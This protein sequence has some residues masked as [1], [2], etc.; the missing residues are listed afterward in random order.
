MMV[1]HTHSP[2]SKNPLARVFA[3]CFWFMAFLIALFFLLPP[4][5]LAITPANKHLKHNRF[6]KKIGNFEGELYRYRFWNGG[7]I[8]AIIVG[9]SYVQCLPKSRMIA[10][11]GVTGAS[12][13]ECESL[14]KYRRNDELIF[15]VVSVREF[16]KY[17]P[18]R[19]TLIYQPYR[20]AFCAKLIIRDS[21]LGLPVKK[22]LNNASQRERD[23]L[24]MICGNATALDLTRTARQLINLDLDEISLVRYNKLHKK[25]SNIIFIIFPVAPLQWSPPNGERVREQANVF[26][27]AQTKLLSLFKA[28][29][30]P[31]YVLE[32]RAE[33]YSDL[34]HQDNVGCHLINSQLLHFLDTSKKT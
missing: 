2:W 28:S 8:K 19:P 7:S 9:P 33:H 23:V 10:N 11:F 30:L 31:H 18:K 17:N 15:W 25:Y 16:L 3:I 4:Q 13:R 1:Q 27:S 32:V 34:W 12:P 21:L 6:T 29:D 22:A 24:K 5:I 26:I 14:L 20:N